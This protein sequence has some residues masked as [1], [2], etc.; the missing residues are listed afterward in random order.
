MSDHHNCRPAGCS[1]FHSTDRELTTETRP[2]SEG[3]HEPH[4]FGARWE[5]V[6]C[7]RRY[8]RRGLGW[9]PLS[10]ALAISLTACGSSE[11]PVAAIEPP[12]SQPPLAETNREPTT[13]TVP[14]RTTTTRR[15]SRSGRRPAS[16]GTSG[17]CDLDT[18]KARESGNNYGAVSASGKYRGAHQFDRPTWH[19]AAIRAGYPEWADTPVNEVPPAVQD[20]VAAQLY[21]ERG[22]QPWSVCR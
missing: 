13:T 2:A 6:I 12:V 16:G 9:V 11:R 1:G 19:G 22:S 5:C 10:A 4:D 14:P 21:S 17:A 7:G 18:I 3:W 20:A 15:V 8:R